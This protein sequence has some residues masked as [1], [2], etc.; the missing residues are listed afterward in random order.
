MISIPIKLN[1]KAGMIGNI[2]TYFN[3]LYFTGAEL[4][5]LAMLSGG[6]D[7]IVSVLYISLVLKS[8]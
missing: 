4:P 8:T 3:Q 7:V 5:G 6:E 1:T 2:L